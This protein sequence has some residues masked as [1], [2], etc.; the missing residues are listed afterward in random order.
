MSNIE[1]HISPASGAGEAKAKNRRFTVSRK[2][3]LIVFAIIVVGTATLVTLGAQKQRADL[4]AL[5]T[6]SNGTISELMAE[7]M[8]GGL[9]WKKTKKIV[10]VYEDLA[11]AEHSDLSNVLTFDTSGKIV[12]EYASSTL[13]FKGLKDL[14]ISSKDTFLG[15][16]SYRRLEGQH[17]LI[18]IP[19]NDAKGKFVGHAV[20]TWS[21]AR[22]ESQ[23]Q[24]NMF[25][26]L[27]VGLSVLI[28]SIL[29]TALL[30]SHIITRPLSK[31]T[32][33]MTALAAGDTSTEINGT[34][35]KDD[36]GDMSQAVQIFK[37]NA[38][39]VK[40][41][42]AEQEKEAK[43][44]ALR[45]EKRLQEEEKRKEAEIIQKREAEESA[46]AERST[47]L[48]E[49]AQKLEI[50]VDSVAEQMSQ[51]TKSM[52]NQ[53]KM[54]LDGAEDTANHSSSI[55]N[56]SDQAAK[57]VEGVAAATEELSSSLQEIN[58]Q[59]SVSSDLSNKTLNETEETN[60][61]V[62][63]LASSADEI[64]NVVNLINDIAE[65]T[66]LLA[67]NATI[68]AARAG[69]AGKGFAVVASEVKSLAS[70]TT[71]ATEE[72]ASQIDKMQSVTADAVSAVHQ[73]KSMISQINETVASIASSLEEQND[74]TQEISRNVQMASTRT[75]EVS[76]DV[77]KVS[78][79]A[80]TSGTAANDLLQS[81]GGL[82]QQS[83]TLKTEMETILRDI[84]SMA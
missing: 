34:S 47:L 13:G 19:V 29:L 53:A 52:E 44:K 45:E 78:S 74:A 84:R 14:L 15:T 54:L 1:K 82:S 32:S 48:R 31:L 60:R 27:V 40:A 79:M 35:R 25:T 64:G 30:L 77:S 66:N 6:T 37:E 43:D 72:I 69:D 12:T 56:S 7:Q 5:S 55:A 3:L 11:K 61:V 68:E 17:Q 73:I 70:Q 16:E 46:A 62:G 49:L 9:R 67:L 38:L 71:K 33:A 2:I 57:N 81:A 26:Q 41:L 50:S 76:K 75:G 39:Q 63:E 21:L 80:N 8:S 51:S 59:I 18:A 4:T 28:V 36:M 83:E 23:L 24:D 65:Q 42:E 58:R 20:F 10:E 22:M